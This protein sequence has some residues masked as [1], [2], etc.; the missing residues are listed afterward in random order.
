MRLH[1]L[2]FDFEP[3]DA[4]SS[5]EAWLSGAVTDPTT[6]FTAEEL[7]THVRTE[8]STYTWLLEP[9]IEHAGFAIL[10]RQ[11][12]RSASPRTRAAPAVAS[13]RP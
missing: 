4:G 13:R 5:I 9:M 7:A 1:D 3:A 11:Y 2:V 8:F 6:G 12:R 10:D